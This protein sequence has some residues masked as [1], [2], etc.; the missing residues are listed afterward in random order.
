MLSDAPQMHPQH[1]FCSEALLMSVI[2][3]CHRKCQEVTS[4]CTKGEDNFIIAPSSGLTRRFL[5]L[6]SY[7]VQSQVELRSIKL[8]ERLQS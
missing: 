2:Q 7:R 6:V 8:T 1:M 5:G 3:M 4:F